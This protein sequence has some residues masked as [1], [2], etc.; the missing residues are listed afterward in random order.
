[1]TGAVPPATSKTGTERAGKCWY[2]VYSKPRQ[3]KAAV[4]NL[5]RQNYQVYFPQIRIWRTRRRN[6]QLVVEPLFPRYLFIHLDSQSDNWAPIRS[7]LG[8]TSLVR[9]GAEPA[10]VPDELIAYLQSRQNA[11]GLHEWAQPTIAIGGRARVV[12]GPLAGYEGILI[13]KSSR[14]RV[15]ILMD[16]VGGQV[17]I[18]LNP[19]QIEPLAR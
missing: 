3:E 13:A 5:L 6:R 17:R 19:D 10:R 1:M 16:L 8:V 2:L 11:E 7:T 15:I 18:K 4:E 12:S 9:F 14:E